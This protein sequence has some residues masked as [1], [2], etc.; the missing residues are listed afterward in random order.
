MGSGGAKAHESFSIA[1]APAAAAPADPGTAAVVQASAA[2][3]VAIAGYNA[4]AAAGISAINNAATFQEMSAA[5]GSASAAL[6]HS[7]MPQLSA[8]AND[9]IHAASKEWLTGKSKEELDALAIEAGL[10]HPEMVSHKALAFWLDPS[11][12]NAIEQKAKVAAAAVARYDEAVATGKIIPKPD[13]PEG[14]WLATPEEAGKAYSEV[15]VVADKVTGGYTV[16]QADA[17]LELV[18]AENK[19]AAAYCP[20]LGHSLDKTKAEAKKIVTEKLGMSTEDL[21]THAIRSLIKDGGELPEGVG[22]LNGSDAFELLRAS[23]PQS[24]KDDIGKIIEA[25]KPIHGEYIAAHDV[26]KNLTVGNGWYNANAKAEFT[27]DDLL[28]FNSSAAT[29]LAHQTKIVSWGSADALESWLPQD[30]AAKIFRQGAKTVPV[31][32]IRS[33][34]QE[35]GMPDT[36]GASRAQ[37][38]NWMIGQWHNQIDPADIAAEIAAKNNKPAAPAGSKAAAA[39]TPASTAPASPAASAAGGTGTVVSLP[40]TAGSGAWLAKQ[41]QTIAALKHHAASLSDMPERPAASD[42]S[43]W[44]FTEGPSMSLG[45]AHTKSVKTAPDGS[46]WMFKPAEGHRAISEASANGI[47]HRV[48]IPTVPVYKHKVDGKHGTVQPLMKGAS[49]FNADP[50]KWSQGDVDAIVRY[51]AAAWV[52]GDHDA[53]HDNLLR[54]PS[55]GLVP[56]DHGQA[57]KF[58]GRDKLSTEYHPNSSYGAQPPV[59]NVLY[60]AA[61]TGKL[62][63]GVEVRPAAAAPVIKAFE[64][65]PDSEY[66]GM[67]AP[68]AKAGASSSNS[69]WKETMQKRAAKKF[70]VSSPDAKQIAETFIDYGVERKNGVR[71][72]FMKFF[73]DSGFAGADIITKAA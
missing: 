9:A 38:Q 47:L 15:L 26:L 29:C 4:A 72:A 63:K 46:L 45:G 60:E 37:L 12:P 66:S 31:A 51:H 71:H 69:H 39:G 7:D 19:F 34:A 5:V 24:V 61:K 25:R 10:Q 73:T 27:K 70:G 11:Y 3:D 23:T 57:F 28:A 48:G 49:N 21:K 30:Q 41:K 2:D 44:A 35:L 67:L 59:W 42:V 54:T 36:K 20:E 8:E 17:L 33:G 50:S 6:P 68:I 1:P 65:I 58:W 13:L 55:G 43:G 53:K 40:Q 32:E 16:D 14:A 62:A 22:L 18:N 52:V 56:I 64:S